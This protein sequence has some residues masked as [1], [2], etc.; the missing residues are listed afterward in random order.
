MSID[1]E[2]LCGGCILYEGPPP[3]NYLL[4]LESEEKCPCS[5]CI[6]KT[7]CEVACE[8]FKKHVKKSNS[9]IRRAVSK[10]NVNIS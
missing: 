3:C 2:K 8:E 10:L 6:I 9:E 4:L 1:R 5:E 7:P